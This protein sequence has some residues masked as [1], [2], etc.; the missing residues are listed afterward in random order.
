M[1]LLAVLLLAQPIALR[2]A[3]MFDARRGAIVQ[4]GLVVVEGERIVEVGRS[5]PP[6]A[7]TIDL[8]D[9]TLLPGLMDA[10]THLTFESGPSWYRDSFDVILRWPAEQAQYAAEYARRTLD[11]GFT[12]VR[13]LGASDFIDVGLKKAIDAGAV[14]G[15]RMITAVHA[16]GSR[17]GH[18]DLDPYPPDR[19]PPLGI[20]EG[21]CDG[22]EAC[23]SAVRWQVKYG[24]GVV[25]L[26]ASGGVLSLADPVDNVQLSQ[27]EL[28]AIVDE[29]H[30]WGR[31]AAA[32]SHGD[33]AAKM[34]VRA[35]GD[36]V[37]HGT[38]LKPD[39]LQ[40]MK[41]HG[42]FLMPGPIFDPKGQSREELQ[43]K[44]PPPIVEKALAA[45]KA[46]PE[47]IRN[48]Q[49]I[50]V[51]IAF[52]SDAGVGEHGK[53]NPQQLSWMV[54]WGFT[55]AAALQSATVI[56]AELLG[57]D[58]GILE[59]GKLADVIAVP[60][61]PLQDITAVER[62]SF[63]MKGGVV[64][65]HGALPVP[66]KKLALK[67]AHLFDAEKGA[68]IDGAT[69]LIDGDR[70]TAAGRNVQVPRDATTIDLGD[71][72]L[73]PGLID[74]HVHLTGESQEDFAKA[75]VESLFQFP[76]ETTLAARVYARRT[77]LGGFT[78]VRN[79]GASDL[80]DFGLKRGIELGFT[81]GP[82]ML[83]SESPIGSRG[84]HTDGAPAPPTHLSPRTVEAGI[85]AGADQCRDAVRWQL[86]YG[87][88]VIKFAVSGGVLSLS[89]PVDVPQ[90]TAEETAAIVDEAHL[91][92][93]KAAAHC[94]GDA[95][96]KIAIAAG[97]DSIEHGSFL[98]PETLAEMKRRGVVYV[99]T[100]M[101]VENVERRAREKKLPALVAEKALQAASS[102]AN[103]FRTA[104]QLGVPI[105]LGTDSGVS[106]HGFNAHEITLMVKNGMTPAQAL[107]AG[108]VAGAKLLQM[109]DR[110][111]K[112]ATG[113]L[114]DV[115]AVP[116][117]VLQD[118]SAIERVSLVVKGGRIVK[119]P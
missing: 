61:N 16:V 34:F 112:L 89:D 46:W 83:V 6:G 29:A 27:A 85:C 116:G 113:Y 33:A 73:L 98:K 104:V 21:I 20:R 68:L 82:R 110:V 41:K 30:R 66:P 51:R 45:G 10:H 81:D 47:M 24:A 109:D 102:L 77:L 108:T 94:H 93:K 111:G 87:A 1:V 107:Q 100:L 19:V 4:P 38:F 11:S 57:I 70:I 28:D 9:A 69:V 99:P 17:G 53:T 3:R 48:A 55:P 62:V 92:R 64:V 88:D 60:G 72:T 26:M 84:G 8:G 12:A 40:E 86:K 44:F 115:I 7:K 75:V 5:A 39:T 54:K 114:A 65:K 71:A 74:A 76:A 13:D 22:V 106:Q 2:A 103:T 80:T 101:A 118:P 50:G 59:K 52:G 78:T 18:A 79:V 90:L 117:N 119:Q 32:H 43:K 58:A 56:D 42:V 67:A 91:W 25:K 95:A 31:R 37:E 97:V 36:S 23:R 63:V 15:P 105:A 14:P 35:G 49:R 96:A